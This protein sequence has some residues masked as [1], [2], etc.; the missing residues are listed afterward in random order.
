MITLPRSLPVQQ[1]ALSNQQWVP[2]HGPGD[3]QHHAP[4]QNG[5]RFRY[6]VDLVNA[7]VPREGRGTRR[8]HR[9]EPEAHG[10]RH[11][12]RA[13]VLALQPSWRGAALPPLSKL[14]IAPAR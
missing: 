2:V 6:T 1:T 7:L 10:G 3:D 12:L 5:R 9:D 14:H 4:R 11:P 13:W 8:T